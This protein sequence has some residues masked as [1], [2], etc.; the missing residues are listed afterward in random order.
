MIK[1]LIVTLFVLLCSGA[2]YNFFPEDELPKNNKIDK[3]IV[4]KHERI[5][6]AYSHGKLL[7]TYS[8]S[9]G[10]NPIGDK[11]FQG[12]YR[13]P[14]GEY[15]INDKNPKSGFHKNLGISYPNTRDI[16]EARSKGFDPGGDI[17]IH[18]H[19]NGIG[20]IG[21]F[22]LFFDWTAGCI[23]VTN[24]EMDELYESVD[25]GTPIIIKP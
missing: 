12:D 8:I 19:K 3:L 13:T 7:K 17:K 4:I 23:A 1:W 2:V 9:L 16:S 18:G 5:M 25:V 10:K 24:N 20:F 15:I 22:H 21:K 14:E 6:E 11:K